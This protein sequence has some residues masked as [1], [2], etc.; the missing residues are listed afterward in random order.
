MVLCAFIIIVSYYFF[1]QNTKK[2]L[3]KFYY[4]DPLFDW[5]NRTE[6]EPGLPNMIGEVGAKVGLGVKNTF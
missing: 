6:Q 5:C 4:V 1:T 3:V 2:M